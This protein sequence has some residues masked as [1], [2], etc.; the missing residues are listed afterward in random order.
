MCWGTIFLT[1]ANICF[2]KH[3]FYLNQ[4]E[5]TKQTNHTTNKH[6]TQTFIDFQKAKFR[7]YVLF[8]KKALSK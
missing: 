8:Q 4:G 3:A 7:N 1:I 5:T 6:Q 2:A